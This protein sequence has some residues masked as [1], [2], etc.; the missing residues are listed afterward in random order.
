MN[1]TAKKTLKI[2]GITLGS[3]LVLVLLVLLFACWTLFSPSRLTKVASKAI[4]KYAPCPVQIDKV[5]LT[6]VGTYPFL[7]FRLN[8]L[9]IPDEMEASPFDTLLYVN[10]FTVTVDFKALY[11]ENKIILTNLNLEKVQAN[12]FT[13][14]DGSSN[15]DFLNSDEEKP[16]KEDEGMDIYADLQKIALSD[17]TGR[18]KDRMTGTDLEAVIRDLDLKGLLHYDSLQAKFS[19]NISIIEA[20]VNNDSTDVA[21]IISNLAIKG[22]L[23]KYKDDVNCNLNASIKETG[24]RAGDMDALI[25]NLQL[26]LNNTHVNL[27]GEKLNLKTGMSMSA[28]DLKFS[29]DEMATSTGKIAVKTNLAQIID[30]SIHVEGFT[31]DSH[32]IHLEMADS[33]GNIT[34]SSI[35]SL[36]LAIDGGLK[37]D[38][39]KVNTGLKV[40]LAGTSFQIEGESPMQADIDQATFTANGIIN[41]DEIQLESGFSTPA[42][43]LTMNGEQMIPGWPVSVTVPLNTNREITRFTIPDDAKISVNGESISMTAN[44]T[45]GGSSI[46][47]G[48]AQVKT[49]KMNIDKVVSMIPESYQDVLDGIDIHGILGMNLNLKAD[50]KESGANVE[51]ADAKLT[52]NNFDVTLNDS[53]SAESN[54]L[55]LDIL[56]PSIVAIDKTRETADVVLKAGD[57]K[58]NVVDSAM[59]DAA[60][61]DLWLSASVIGLTDTLPEMNIRAEVAFSHLDG[62]MDTISGK[63]DNTELTVTIAPADKVTAIMV[64]GSFDK[65]NAV[66]GSMLAAD[67]GTTSLLAMAQYDESKEDLLLKWS[68]RLK[69][70]LEDGRIDMLEEPVLIPQLDMDFSLGR[71]NI[72]DCRVETCNSDIML[73]GDVYNIGE[74]LDGTGL[75]TGE[76]FLESD[77]VDVTSIMA[78]TGSDEEQQQATKAIVEQAAEGADTIQTGPFMVPK[79]IDLTLYTNLSEIDFNGHL[80]NNVGGDV[81]VKDGV[82][83]LQELGFSSDAAE[84]QLTAIYKTPSLEDRFMEL[85]FHLLDIE[86]DELI[87]LIPAVDSIVPMLKAFS[88]K[89]QFHLAAETYLEPDTKLHG[90]YYPV[91][92][93][94]IGAAAIEGQNLVVLDNELFDGIKK[95]LLMSKDA[96]NVI[97]SLDVELQVL[98]DKVDLYPTRLRMDRYEA[99]LGGRHNINQSLDCNYHISLTDSPLPVRLGVTISGP[100]E[101]ISSSPLKH[102]KLEKPRYSK[103]YKTEKR[104]TTE[105]R[106]L[107]MK[108]DILETLRSNVR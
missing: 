5:D 14:A 71:F 48:T 68:P 13:D 58:V 33:T 49:S 90:D 60:F 95:K 41:N 106:V 31:F 98:R 70:T 7:G 107:S 84:M 78:M 27:G 99:I 4:D 81:T 79:G 22:D 54:G 80:F 42:V 63:L 44:G 92:S 100:I 69:L 1:K 20:T 11:K 86:I 83:V 15:I 47:R 108:Q 55:S 62:S 10:D 52:L 89:A 36:L 105:E 76:L 38:L 39:T 59:I 40:D 35:T 16:E 46:V 25:H 102:I 3:I 72:N 57:L 64:N 23:D 101:G 26:A 61:D 66:M 67:L 50:L 34:R 45:M 96:R 37:T 51:K 19:T 77:H 97:D 103:L 30:D 43:Y 32:E 2:T 56:Y 21:A 65:L 17:I 94:L 12:L 53:I 93:T 85:D 73:W 24:A 91:M 18:Y 104:G 29:S 87:D 75:L 8:G 6:L 88:G 28:N 82:V 74:Y 9:Y